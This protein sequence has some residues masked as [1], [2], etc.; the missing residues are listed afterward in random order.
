VVLYKYITTNDVPL[1]VIQ[2]KITADFV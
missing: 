1:K 2:L